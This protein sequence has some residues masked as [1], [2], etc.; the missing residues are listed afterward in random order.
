MDLE[1]SGIL[2]LI[3]RD[4]EPGDYGTYSVTISNNH[5]TATSSAKLCPDSKD[6]L[7]FLT[8]QKLLLLVLGTVV[9]LGFLITLM[10]PPK[11]Y[12]TPDGALGDI[13]DFV[14]RCTANCECAEK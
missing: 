4:V 10:L 1:S 11:F 9:A 5:G 12:C 6:M 2:R 14:Y 8:P 13:E 3:I 7:E